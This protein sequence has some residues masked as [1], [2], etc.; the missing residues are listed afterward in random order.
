MQEPPLASFRA[1][2]KCVVDPGAPPHAHTPTFS[3]T[4]LRVTTCELLYG[5]FNCAFAWRLDNT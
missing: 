2:P 4:L 3:G 1:A 5:P